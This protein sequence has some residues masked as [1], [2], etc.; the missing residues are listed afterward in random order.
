M[1]LVG[2]VIGWSYISM[3]NNNDS[4]FVFNQSTIGREKCTLWS[5]YE[6]GIM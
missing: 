1:I 5:Q 4:D 6:W 2:F 3:T